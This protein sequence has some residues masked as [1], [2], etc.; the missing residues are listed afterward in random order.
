[1]TLQTCKGGKEAPCLHSVRL[2]KQC[3]CA[4]EVTL[5][6]MSQLCESHESGWV[7]ETA[8]SS[9][10]SF[11]SHCEPVT[12]QPCGAAVKLYLHLVNILSN[13]QD[14]VIDSDYVIMCLIQQRPNLKKWKHNLSVS[15][16]WP[17]VITIVFLKAPCDFHIFS[18]SISV[19]RLNVWFPV[20]CNSFFLFFSQSLFNQR[21]Q[22]VNKCNRIQKRGVEFYSASGGERLLRTWTW[23][24]T[25]QSGSGQCLEF[26]GD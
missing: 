9:R 24:S 26:L 22:Q 18:F 23:T 14:M 19:T 13:I 3:V 17:G 2:S 25:L 6:F 7:Q 21:R 8:A 11:Y 12:L 1:M 15:S 16:E 4:K 20:S 5:L 10:H